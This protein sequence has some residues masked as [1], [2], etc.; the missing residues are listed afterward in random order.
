[1]GMGCATDPQLIA[2]ATDMMLD[3]LPPAPRAWSLLE[4]YLENGMAWLCQPIKR[5]HI[6]EDFLTPIYNAKKNRE[7]SGMTTRT[8]ISSHKLAVFFVILAIGAKMDF[9]L[10]P[11]NEEGTAYYHHA[12]A[13]LSHSAIFDS[14]MID[15]VH[16]ILLISRFPNERQSKDNSYALI[17]LACKLALSVR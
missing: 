15:T 3:H 2:E 7:D 17:G 1:M 12:R 11:N 10:P 9:T 16:A 13:A 6:I 5:E 8:R 4:A 14:P